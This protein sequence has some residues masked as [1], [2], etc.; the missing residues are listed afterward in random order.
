MKYVKLDDVIGILKLFFEIDKKGLRT[1]VKNE[2]A[3]VNHWLSGIPTLDLEANIKRL[4]NAIET[5]SKR[6]GEERV[7]EG[8]LKTKSIL[9]GET[10]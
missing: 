10:K 9:L 3:F 4:N 1:T 8:M 5:I 6:T 2:E 7:V